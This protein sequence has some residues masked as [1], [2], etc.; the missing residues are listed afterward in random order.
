[1]NSNGFFNVPSGKKK[2]IKTYDKENIV[3]LHE[4]FMD[5]N[6]TILRE[7]FC[8]AVKSKSPGDFVYFDPPYD[9]FDDKDSFTSYTKFNFSKDDKKDYQFCL[10]NYQIEVYM[11]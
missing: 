8:Y 10:K 6:V 9:S 7:T 1:M 4:Y 3:K 5:K 11:S 2:K